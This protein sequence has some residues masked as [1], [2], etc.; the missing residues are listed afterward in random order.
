M[1]KIKGGE[2]IFSSSKNTAVAVTSIEKV[3]ELEQTGDKDPYRT[4]R[5]DEFP[6]T[7]KNN[8]CLSG[9][10]SRSAALGR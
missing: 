10:H 8:G 6:E 3:C 7:S 1:S 9:G 5:C 2:C 4:Y